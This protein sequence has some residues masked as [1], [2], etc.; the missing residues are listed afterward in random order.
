MLLWDILGASGG[1]LVL[2]LYPVLFH[3]VSE[4]VSQ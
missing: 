2:D 1:Y 4:S 3:G